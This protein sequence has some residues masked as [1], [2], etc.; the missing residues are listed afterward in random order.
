MYN[1]ILV[2]IGFCMSVVA[3]GL[4]SVSP[5]LSVILWMSVGIIVVA[6]VCN[7]CSGRD[8]RIP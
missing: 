1:L 4:W 2:S 3:Y 5:I 8:N 6:V 7:L